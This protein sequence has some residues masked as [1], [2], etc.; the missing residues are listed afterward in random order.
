[1]RASTCPVVLVSMPF[2]S[3]FTPSMGLSLLK[4]SLNRAG[5]PSRVLYFTLP[6]ARRV[7][8]DF[9]CRVGE[10]GIPGIRELAGEWI[11]SGALFGDTEAGRRAYVTDVLRNRRGWVTA[12]DRPVPPATVNRILRAR[13]QVHGFLDECVDRIARIA[14]RLVGFTS[15]FQ[16]QAASLAL[17]SRLREALPDATIILGGGNCE[18]VMGSE[19][20]RQFRFL[21]G[22]F[23]G[24]ADLVFPEIARRA[25][26]A[27]PIAGIPGLKTASDAEREFLTRSFSNAP[28]V[29][30]MD[31]LPRADFTDFFEQ[32]NATRYGRHWQPRVFFETSRGCW[33]GEKQ[34][35][36][37]CGLNGSTMAFRSK[38]WQRALDELAE[39]VE[40]YPDS[41]IQ[42]VDNILD[43]RYFND[44]LPA[45]AARGLKTELFFETKS[46]LRKDQLRALK[47]ASVADIQPGI[48][49]F[50]D[51]VLA[52]MRKG[53]TGLQNVQLLKWCLEIGVTP[54]WNLLWGFPGEPADDYAW[55]ARLMPLISH[56]RPPTFFGGIRLDR[57]S[58]NFAQ[59]ETLGFVDVEPL[60]AYRHVYPL[61]DEA[62]ANLAYHF[63]FRYREPR[64]VDAYMRPVLAALRRWRRSSAQS[65]LFFADT[66]EHLVIIDLRPAARALVTILTG[67][68]RR[69]YLACDAA[70]DVRR[71]AEV[72]AASPDAAVIAATERRLAGLIERGLMIRSGHRCL[73]LAVRLGEYTP[74]DQIAG[75]FLAFAAREGRAVRDVVE[76]ALQP[77]GVGDIRESVPARGQPSVVPRDARPTT[78]TNDSFVVDD[79]R[80]L[81]VRPDSTRSMV[82]RRSA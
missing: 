34:H 48:E 80:G 38:S 35:C 22:V 82:R 5:I 57:F 43:M 72:A 14:P 47:R 27:E 64:D 52:L 53:V 15:V 1:M 68:D 78:L 61:P 33:W 4:G 45:I 3:M 28:P 23:S 74:G 69:L 32:F 58:P 8:R 16:Q 24:E 40:R 55:T 50:G 60:A 49:S 70:T 71:L 39:L 2:G 54:H 21:D 73:A 30:N 59:A 77:S 17:A 62:V 13:D 65:A 66:G 44:L 19:V 81:V 56:L 20:A 75:R 31:D 10:D 7:G 26:A 29:R 41:D 11:F 46:N 9:Y 67:L 51:A 37:F 18:G 36:T 25:I 12:R 79:Q 42:V 76:I 6:F 63:S